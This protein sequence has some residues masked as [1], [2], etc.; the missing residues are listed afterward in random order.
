MYCMCLI[1]CRQIV[2][3]RVQ[4]YFKLLSRSTQIIFTGEWRILIYQ[5]P[6]DLSPR[7]VLFVLFVS[8]N[9][10]YD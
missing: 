3:L 2:R 5:R 4:V 10:M 7:L 9:Q 8:E 6:V 1:M